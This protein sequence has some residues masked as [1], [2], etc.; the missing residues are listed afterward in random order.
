MQEIINH[1]QDQINN[2]GDINA[3]LKMQEGYEQQIRI[4]EH[5]IETY[6]NEIFDIELLRD[7]LITQDKLG[8]ARRFFNKVHEGF[9]YGT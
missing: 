3:R 9:T 5:Y 1:L 6:Q 2:L 4:N 8:T 7:G